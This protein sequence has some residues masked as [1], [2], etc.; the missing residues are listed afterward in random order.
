MFEHIELNQFLLMW[1]DFIPQDF[2]K[3]LSFMPKYNGKS[4]KCLTSIKYNRSFL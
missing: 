2:H 4:R 1:K 3:D